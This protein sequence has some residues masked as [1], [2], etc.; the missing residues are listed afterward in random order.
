VRGEPDGRFL[1]PGAT[2]TMYKFRGISDYYWL[3]RSPLFLLV[4][5]I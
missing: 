5:V 4:A 3:A 1:K 2:G